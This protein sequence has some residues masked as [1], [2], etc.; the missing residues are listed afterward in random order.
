MLKS[1]CSSSVCE[2]LVEVV[3]RV[4]AVDADVCLVDPL[5][6]RVREVELVLDVA[7]DLLEEVLER[8]DPFD[9]AVLVDD[10]RKVLLLTAEVG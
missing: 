7:D 8:H 3:D 4:G 5:D 2:L 10:D 1:S 6:G 9:V